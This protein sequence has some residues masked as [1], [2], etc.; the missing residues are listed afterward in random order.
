MKA[1]VD[2]I[3]CR[4]KVK[5]EAYEQ[6]LKGQ[7]TIYRDTAHTSAVIATAVSLAVLQRQHKSKEEIQNFFEEMCLIYDFP[8]VFGKQLALDDLI[9]SLEKDY[10]IDFNKIK[11]HIE[12]EKEFITTV[13]KLDKERNPSQSEAE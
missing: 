7:Y 6:F 1:R 12:N 2:C 10:D 4:D 11:L 5:K 3:K 8:E 13:K 9:A